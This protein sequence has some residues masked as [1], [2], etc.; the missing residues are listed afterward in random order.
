MLLLLSKLDQAEELFDLQRRGVGHAPSLVARLAAC[1][2]GQC[3]VVV[4]DLALELTAAQEELQ[5]VS[6]ELA[7]LGELGNSL[8]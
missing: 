7:F 1:K 3:E 8:I 4:R 2:Q 6:Q 5:L